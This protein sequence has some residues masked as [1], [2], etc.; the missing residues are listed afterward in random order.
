M[1]PSFHCA[2]AWPCSAAYCSDDKPFSFS[3]ARNDCAPLTK[4]S[5]GET[6]G[7]AG[8]ISEGVRVPSK[9]KAGASV[10]HAQA[11]T[12]RERLLIGIADLLGF[13][14][15]MRDRA[16]DRGSHLLSV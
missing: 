6:C 2:I 8:F 14:A 3:P 12:M 16:I 10:K 1:R 7:T 11:N 4:A 13:A 5:R 15:W 9:A